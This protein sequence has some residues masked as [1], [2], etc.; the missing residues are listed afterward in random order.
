MKRILLAGVALLALTAPAA[1]DPILTP[2]IASIA[3]GLSAAGTAISGA[4]AALGISGSTLF[5]IGFNLVTSL[6]FAPKG[7]KPQDVQGV[8]RQSVPPRARHYGVRRLGG[9]LLFIETVRGGLYQVIA[10]GQGVFDGFEEFI[11]DNRTVTLD[12]DGYVTSEPY[13]ANANGPFVQIKAQTGT[14]DQTAHALLVEKFPTIW[15]ADHRNRGIANAMLYARRLGASAFSKKY[16]NRIPLLNAIARTSKLYDPRRPGMSQ[17]DSST[18]AFT[19]TALDGG[20][21]YSASPGTNIAL[22]LADYLTHSDGMQVPADLIDWDSVATAADVCDEVLTNKVGGSVARYHGGL[23]YAL[24]AEPKDIISRFLQAMDGRLYL[25]PNGT[26]A[27]LAGTWIEPTVTIANGDIISYEMSDGSGPLREANEVIV[28]YVNG[29]AQFIEMSC[30]PWRDDDDIAL[31]GAVKSLPVEAYEVENHNHARRLAKIIALRSSP[32]WQGTIV[33]NLVGM[34]AL[35]QRFIT[36]QID[37]LEIDDTF[38]VQGITVD[39]DA[40]TVTMR[41]IAFGPE[42][43]EF[44]AVAEE[45]TEPTPPELLEEDAVETP[46]NL[47]V[48]VEQREVAGGVTVAVIVATWDEPEDD[49]LTA[50]AQIAPSGTEAWISMSVDNGVSRAESG[51]NL[52]DGADYDIRVRF[53]GEEGTVS[54]WVEV[55]GIT[56]IADPVAPAVP[57]DLSVG[58][59]DDPNTALVEWTNPTSENV[60]YSDIYTSTTNDSAGATDVGSVY[61]F[62]G[63]ARAYQS[64]ALATATTHYFWVASVNASGVASARTY[65][66]SITIP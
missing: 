53:R 40:M 58:A 66:G 3:T 17:S 20:T 44:D 33:T 50:Q 65:A 10:F 22:Q 18:W 61:G 5:T 47:D 59:G 16:P 19:D 36:V 43:Y 12:G 21:I 64:A 41:V 60:R 28:K 62:P 11:I 1:A 24:T 52:V 32:R 31:T 26:I 35:D 57:T 14:D 55:T 42:A 51:T 29:S 34:Q 2:L 49:G 15:S 37:D 63:E 56:A 54:E 25:K 39:I 38:E 46:T 48:S 45:G 4:L 30:D 13:E 6:L 8:I 9:S 7:P 23:S 27:M